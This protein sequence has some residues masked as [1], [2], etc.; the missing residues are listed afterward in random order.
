MEKEL[1][2]K[3]ELKVSMNGVNIVIEHESKGLKGSLEVQGDYLLDLLMEAIPGT[4]DDAVIMMLKG[5][6]KG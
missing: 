3:G 2:N 4:I 5:A 6:L 1:F